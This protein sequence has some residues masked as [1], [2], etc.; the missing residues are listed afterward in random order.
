MY[1]FYT[2]DVQKR[3][4][5]YGQVFRVEEKIINLLSYIKIQ[6]SE[7]IQSSGEKLRWR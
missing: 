6:R 1:E 7:K 4:L 2:L 5:F 3:H